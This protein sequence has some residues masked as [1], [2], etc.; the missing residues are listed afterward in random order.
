MS[1]ALLGHVELADGEIGRAAALLTESAELLRAIGNP[2][3]LPWCLEGLAGVA[4]ARGQWERAAQL[5]GARDA[6]RASRAAPLPTGPPGWPCR[7]A[8]RC[9]RGARGG[10]LFGGARGR[11]DPAAG[12]GAG[13][14]GHAHGGRWSWV[15]G[16]AEAVRAHSVHPCRLG[17][18][19]SGYLANR[20]RA[21]DRRGGRVVAPDRRGR[22]GGAAPGIAARRASKHRADSPV[23]HLAVRQAV[24]ALVPGGRGIPV[25]QVR[26]RRGGARRPLVQRIR[27]GCNPGGTG[28][29]GR[30]GGGAGSGS[31]RTCDRGGRASDGSTRSSASA[32]AGREGRGAG[33]YR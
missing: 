2:L 7:R 3:Y 18:S 11:A 6:I 26:Q 22:A 10:R 25:V 4:A 17:R 33:R 15:S 28:A 27:R 19:G 9:A 23:V 16:A 29:T 13:R 12:P 8:L 30:I 14:R 32:S 1:L 31:P 24:R 5:C 21:A 20:T